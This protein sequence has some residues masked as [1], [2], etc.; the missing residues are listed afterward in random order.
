MNPEMDIENQEKSQNKQQNQTTNQI[1]KQTQNPNQMRQGIKPSQQNDIKNQNPNQQNISNQQYPQNQL[2]QY[3]QF[4][5]TFQQHP[6][7]SYPYQYTQ[8]FQNQLNQQNPNS[9]KQQNQMNPN[10]ISQYQHYNQQTPLNPYQLQQLQQLQQYH[11]QKEMNNEIQLILEE[12]KQMEEKLKKVKEFELNVEEFSFVRGTHKK[13]IQKVKKYEEIRNKK[14]QLAREWFVF[15]LE[16]LKKIFDD[17]M[18]RANKEFHSECKL[19]SEN[20]LSEA[21]EQ[22]K[23]ILEGK[24]I[25]QSISGNQ[26]SSKNLKKRKLRKDFEQDEDRFLNNF[27]EIKSLKKSEIEKDL[28]A[29]RRQ[30]SKKGLNTEPVICVEGQI[31]YFGN[32]KF[33][34]GSGVSLIHDNG[35]QCGIIK[36]I[37]PLEITLKLNDGRKLI[38]PVTQL[39]EKNQLEFNEVSNYL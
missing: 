3:P 28:A 26:K 23:M 11:Q 5:Y 24:N 8:Q 38:I 4:S 36:R 21:L 10:Q 7:F 34:V 16:N 32:N 30:S 19:V 2:N 22:R 1:S 18:K 27:A 6:Q 15:Q 13:F 17:E 33:T 31:L 14:I 25:N 29:I 37:T 39:R 20:L 12:I 9:L 35:R